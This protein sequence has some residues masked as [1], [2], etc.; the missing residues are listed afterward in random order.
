M[1]KND[2]L[3]S[4]VVPV[5]NEEAEI[6][7]T[8]DALLAIRYPRREIIVVYDQSTDN[9]LEII[10]RYESCEVTVIRQQENQGRCR[11][12]NLG[13]QE[14]AGEIVVILNADV[15]LSADFLDRIVTHYL[16][17]A[18]YVLI[19]S[20]AVNIHRLFPR[21][22][23]AQSHYNYQ[24]DDLIEWTEGYSC[25]R[26]AALDVG[27][28]PDG[29]PIPLC[30]GEDGV[31]GERIARDYRKVVDRSIVVTH[32]IPETFSGY[33]HQQRERGRGTPLILFFV[34]H[35]YFWRLCLRTLVKAMMSLAKLSLL[36]PVL[37]HSLRV[38]Q[39][40][41]RAWRDFLPFWYAYNVQLIAMSLGEWDGVLAI[42][43]E[44]RVGHVEK[45]R[46]D[47]VIPPGT[48]GTEG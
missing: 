34:N 46:W 16:S 35:M 11:A 24:S 33:W 38:S 12:R 15:R 20:H 36:I 43:W 25:R 32:V 23:D 40:S 22:L 45:F 48:V 39:W 5:S 30:S 3:V 4:I 28:F 17:G 13:I 1:I 27:L 6:A 42:W 2:P 14:S 44:I 10:S 7:G 41:E 31:F 47:R 18:D 29:Y 21:F 9:T 19:E 8:L 26:Q 37:W